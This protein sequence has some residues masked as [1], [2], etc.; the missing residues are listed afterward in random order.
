MVEI[1]V[2]QN[3]RRPVYVFLADHFVEDKK[4]GGVKKHTRMTL[5]SLF[6]SIHYHSV[7]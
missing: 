7:D 4:S 5:R 3:L 2:T 1:E 6:D